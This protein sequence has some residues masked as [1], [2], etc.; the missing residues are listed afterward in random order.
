MAVPSPPPVTWGTGAGGAEPDEQLPAS[1]PRRQILSME[2][3]LTPTFGVDAA[4]KRSEE[5]ADALRDEVTRL[6]AE[7]Q[8]LQSLVTEQQEVIDALEQR[9]AQQQA[10]L[11]HDVEA[12]R[13]E[14]D[15]QNNLIKQLQLLVQEQGQELHERQL[16]EEELRR[17]V[18]AAATPR[19]V[20]ELTARLTEKREELEKEMTERKRLEARIE[21]L[22]KQ[23]KVHVLEKDRAATRFSEELRSIREQMQRQM[24]D[25][26]ADTA[27]LKARAAQQF[28]SSDREMHAQMQIYKDRAAKAEHDAQISRNKYEEVDNELHEATEL[29]AR[30]KE[31]LEARDGSSA[32]MELSLREVK[33]E[34]EKALRM[35]HDSLT[36]LNTK[37]EARGQAIDDLRGK[38]AVLEEELAV[39]RRSLSE[40]SGTVAQFETK[41]KDMAERYSKRERKIVDKLMSDMEESVEKMKSERDN[42]LAHVAELRQKCQYPVRESNYLDAAGDM[43]SVEPD[44]TL[45]FSVISRRTA[46]SAAPSP[47]IASRQGLELDVGTQY[48]QLDD[49]AG[50]TERETKQVVALEA[51]VVKLE[52]M[53]DGQN[54]ELQAVLVKLHR[55]Q[56]TNVQLQES[57]DKREDT[58]KAWQRHALEWGN[59]AKRLQERIKELEDATASEQGSAEKNPTTLNKKVIAERERAFG[60]AAT[61]AHS[62][63]LDTAAE[64]LRDI[65]RTGEADEAIVRTKKMITAAFM[66]LCTEADV[67]EKLNTSVFLC[68]KEEVYE[69]VLSKKTCDLKQLCVDLVFRV[70]AAEATNEVHEDVALQRESEVNALKHVNEEL[71]SSCS[72]L[73]AES[74]RMTAQVLQLESDIADARQLDQHRRKEIAC[75]RKDLEEVEARRRNALEERQLNSS[76]CEQNDNSRESHTTIEHD[77][78][79]GKSMKLCKEA[80]ETQ[81]AEMLQQLKMRD[82]KQS[83]MEQQLETALEQLQELMQAV[84][85]M[86]RSRA[87]HVEQLKILRASNAELERQLEVERQQIQEQVQT[88]DK[89]QRERDEIAL[90]HDKMQQCL[91]MQSTQI[92]TLVLELGQ[93]TGSEQ[94]VETVLSLLDARDEELR[95]KESRIQE[96]EDR[97]HEIEK[98]RQELMK[99]LH[100]QSGSLA[101]QPHEIVEEPHALTQM[102]DHQASVGPDSP[103]A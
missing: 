49:G 18:A 37:Y 59:E 32:E 22:Q 53:I 42:A 7:R 47:G 64:A 52:N 35:L 74:L 30:M 40:L 94:Q 9:Q 70:A 76:L 63:A 20:E 92:N 86:R 71:G 4:L 15:S 58:E 87:E 72:S 80:S 54:E 48:N 75:L 16:L 34:S 73:E 97:T 28:E 36:D 85:A 102:I 65:A 31:K 68:A 90:Q 11:D 3:M 13:Q 21:L 84:V 101:R 24:S 29:I 43:R 89:T 10:L 62:I 50:P 83:F 51:Q 25:F 46:Q 99:A 77:I 8:G 88:I 81:I 26:A 67:R 55:L 78:E 5:E 98:S 56:E 44:D 96:L 57:N 91:I 14:V 2:G 19:V 41:S 23:E 79:T 93:C 61:N 17:E 60:S 95:L 27:A 12:V 103:E 38:K 33:A 45:L 82:E 100:G 6:A 39:A 66:E 1:L 69:H